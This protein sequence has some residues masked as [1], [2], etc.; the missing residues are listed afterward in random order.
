MSY[1]ENKMDLE[2]V[3][4]G[5]VARIS[6]EMFPPLSI[7]PAVCLREA[8]DAFQKSG[9][10][11]LHCS[12]LLFLPPTFFFFTPQQKQLLL[13]VLLI[14]LCSRINFQFFN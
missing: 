8:K 4:E 14:F 5:L 2:I 12:R 10:S 11:S 6:D 3:E 1:H 7:A 13:L 9:Y